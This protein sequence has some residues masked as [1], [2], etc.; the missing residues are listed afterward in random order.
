MVT[1]LAAQG[2]LALTAQATD[3]AG[4]VGSSNSVAYTLDLLAPAPV[5]QTPV[6]V[7]AGTTVNIAESQLQ[8]DDNLSSHAQEI[9]SVIAGPAQG[10]LFD[11]GSAASS[12]T[13]ADIDNG[14]V[15]YHETGSSAASDSFTFKVTDAAGNQTAPE[16][17]QFQI[18]PALTVIQTDTG[19]FGTTGLNLV[20]NAYAVTNGSGPG[21]TLQYAGAPI[22]VGEAAFQGWTPIGAIETANGYD[23]VWKEP[24]VSNFQIET[25]DNNGNPL[26][27]G[28]VIAG[29][30][31]ALELAES[32]FHQDLNGDGV[33]GPPT[34]LI[35]ADTGAY[36][37]TNLTLVGNA[38][39]LFNNSGSG[40]LLQYAGAP[41][42]VGEAAFQG[43]TPI[44][45]IETA[46]G[47]DVAWKEPGVSNFQ[48]E[49]ADTNGNPLSWGAVIAGSSY[50][51]ELAETIFNQDLNGDGLIGSP[52]TVIQ[53]DT[54][55]YGTTSLT[56]VGNAYA[57]SNG[58]GPETT[59]QY[60]GAPITVGEAAFQGWT[61]IGAIET[62]NGYDVAWK[63][64]GVS[65]FQIETADSNGNPLSWG[66]VIAG[67]SYALEFAETI[68]NQDLN[69]DGVIGS[70]ATLI[71]TDTGAYGT[72]SLNLVGNAYAVTNGSG[73]G[74]TLQYAGAPITVGEAAFQGWT[75][76]G[77]IETANGYDV[78][79]KE[80]G[81]SNFQ[82]ETV[83]TNGNPLSW[84]AVIAGSSYALEFGRIH[85]PPRPQRRRRDRAS[86]DFDPGRHRGLWHDEPDLGRECVW[87]IQ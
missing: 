66:T 16:Q 7:M 26:S 85:I 73:P 45:A 35:Q 12:F 38:Y 60:A 6:P 54:G 64:P 29:S 83:D 71:Q 57:V 27:W 3:A 18:S 79:W 84:G 70:P 67:S 56:L 28:A 82:I 69:G 42:T 36:D 40:P 47:Y 53:T 24:G 81:V 59:L 34:T 77:A 23:V 43:W 46:N 65:N 2:A 30:S 51:L 44:G 78:A 20:G 17:F 21:T 33:I 49:T 25:A 31:Y 8:F 86:D 14:L 37:T 76:I 11:N 48:I 87:P 50:A 74:T 32:I 39:G 22:T 58:S 80:P 4:N 52:A 63:E 72:T 75:P 41:A 55:A 61:P 13:Q 68:F 10:T 15:S 5:H 1:L 19:A 62:A 9:Y